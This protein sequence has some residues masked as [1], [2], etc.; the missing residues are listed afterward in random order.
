MHFIFQISA[1]YYIPTPLVP[2][3]KALFARYCTQHCEGVWAVVDISVDNILPGVGIM[4]CQKRP[5]GCLIQ[6]T[7]DGNSKVKIQNYLCY[8]TAN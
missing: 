1:E 8:D 4:T 5:S 2:N 6:E 7:V 3:R